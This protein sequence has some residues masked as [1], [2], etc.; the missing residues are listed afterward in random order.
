MEPPLPP[1]TTVGIYKGPYQAR[2]IE[3]P[4][5]LFPLGLRAGRASW[6]RTCINSRYAAVRACRPSLSCPSAA[7][8]H[9]S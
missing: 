2:G 1:G 5:L 9:V 7:A 8:P 4:T 3:E 6:G